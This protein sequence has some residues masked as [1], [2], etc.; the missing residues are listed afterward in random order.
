M[1]V[2]TY[3]AAVAAGAAGLLLTACATG[4]D[5]SGGAAASMA[6]VEPVVWDLTDLYA[7]PEDWEAERA[8]VA[9][10]IPDLDRYEGRLGDSASTLAD[11]Y[12]EVSDL[13][14]RAVQ[15]LV[16]ASL[17]ADEDTRIEENL[18]RNQR[19]E[20]LLTNFSE[21][22]AWM[23]PE[24]L[25]V[26]EA[27]IERFISQEPR[28]EK[29]AFGIR[30]ELRAAPYTL[31]ADEE[32]LLSAAGLP[33][34]GPSRIYNQLSNSD[35]DW[36]TLRIDGEDVRID[37]QGYGLYRQHQNRDVRRRVFDAFWGEWAEY[38]TTMGQT[39]GSHVQGHVF[40]AN[41]RGFD[42][43]RQAAMFPTALPE[44]IYDTLIEQ[45]HEGLPVL[46]RYLRLRGRMLGVDNL[47]YYDIYPELVTLDAEYSVEDSKEIAL[48]TLA[49]FGEE[50][51]SILE[52]GFSQQWMHA[53]P[54][55]GKR[56]GAYMFGS[57]YD[58]HP[59]LFLNHQNDF[60]SLSTFVHE[61]GH[62]VH[63][64]LAAEAQPWETS[65]YATFVAEMAST[66]NEVF[67]LR[68]MQEQA[69]TDDERLFFLSAELDLYR[70]TFFRQTMFA[71]FEHQIHLA[72]QNGEPPTGA[73]YSQIYLDLLRAYHGHDEGV[74]TIDDAYRL[75]WAFIPHFYRNFYVFQYSTS[76]TASTAFAQRLLDNEPG[77]QEAVIEMLRKG[78]SEHPHDMFVAAG[79]DLTTPGPYQAVFARMNEIM[80]DID[81][82]LD[83][84]G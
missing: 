34:G 30:N 14:K 42:T 31:S 59:Y 79:V 4:Q 48:T 5:G 47:A 38:E 33:L 11:A 26:G 32:A 73:A 66:I 24:L 19:A 39:L 71:E 56:S 75:E 15:L 83:R 29:H 49:P 1:S 10:E 37:N 13:Y 16:Y 57:A 54:Q 72:A 20:Q 78:G 58:V 23:T 27:R 51:V 3:L 46:H 53:Y 61:W 62:A 65:D 77:A 64:V 35:I 50:Y 2:K 63:T 69:A 70:G 80:D 7:T 36:P 25:E 43:A 17:K 45:V 74:M 22:I 9:A 28:L 60:D 6:D 67:L 84:Q 12:D 18:A 55:E 68:R 82:I 21:A 76:V 41:A 44:E 40:E 52:D 8:A 81:E